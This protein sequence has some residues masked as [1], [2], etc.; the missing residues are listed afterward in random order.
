LS[1]FALDDEFTGPEFLGYLE[2]LIADRRREMPDG[3]YTAA[4]FAQGLPEMAK[5]VGE[6]AIEVVLSVTQEKRRSIE[7]TADL[8][9]HLLVF[10]AER[11]VPF[12]EVMDELRSRHFK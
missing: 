7:E 9:Y 10:L 1:C 12:G 8:L 3:S 6:E 11:E 2:R 5:K 4:L